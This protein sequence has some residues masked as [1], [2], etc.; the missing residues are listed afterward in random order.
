M[1]RAQNFCM[2]KLVVHKVVGLKR[3]LRTK[4]MMHYDY[5]NLQHRLI[6]NI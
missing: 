1:G 3:F 5:Y 4:N 6:V 2:L